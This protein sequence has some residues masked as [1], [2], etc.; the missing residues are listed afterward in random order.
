MLVAVNDFVRRQKHDSG[1]TYAKTL[2]F[3]EI[4]IHAEK[5]FHGNAFYNGYREGVII[6]KVSEMLIND[7]VCPYVELDENTPLISRIV[8][9]QPN[10]EPYIQTRALSGVRA[11]TGKVELIL[12]R[13]DVLLENDENSS[14]SEWELI[15]FNAIPEGIES[16]PMG[17]ITMMRNQ[18]NLTG[19]TKAIYTIDKWAESVRFWQKY[20]PLE[21]KIDF[22]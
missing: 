9:R 19:G 13:H 16:L 2:S 10:E 21:P 15:S 6:V 17:P 14:N 8:R 22:S 7:F 11:K 20:A 4:A 3:E 5:Q 12:Y 1:K 18:L